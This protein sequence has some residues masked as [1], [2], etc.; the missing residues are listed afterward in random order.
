MTTDRGHLV[1]AMDAMSLIHHV[2]P[3][4]LARSGQRCHPEQH[5]GM[6]CAYPSGVDASVQTCAGT[7]RNLRAVSAMPRA[8]AP[9]S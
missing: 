9:G 6:G 1:I 8:P 4:R 5:R 2:L 7:R 3:L